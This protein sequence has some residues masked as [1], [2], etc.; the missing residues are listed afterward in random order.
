MLAVVTTN[1]VM[2][3][4][5]V[6][7]LSPLVIQFITRL[8]TAA[9]VQAVL[10]FLFILAV[11]VPTAYFAADLDARDYVKSALVVFTL[12]MT[13]YGFLWRPTGI[14]P[15]TSDPGTGG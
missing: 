6:G 10:A 11:S 2:W 3:A 12:A 9:K 7:F 1:A 8:H 13:S 14:T 15:S 4:G 5:I